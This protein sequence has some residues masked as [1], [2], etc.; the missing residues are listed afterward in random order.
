MSSPREIPSDS[1]RRVIQGLVARN[2]DRM[3]AVSHIVLRVKHV[4]LAKE[5][6]EKCIPRIATVEDDGAEGRQMD[7]V[8]GGHVEAR[9]EGRREETEPGHLTV[10]AVENRAGPEQ[11]S[12][13]PGHP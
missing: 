11:E 1:D 9:A 5:F 2:Y 4:P 8:V 12:A 10:A 3:K 6:I 7:G 13:E